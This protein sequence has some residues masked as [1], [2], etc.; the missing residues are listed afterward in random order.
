[1][2]VIVERNCQNDPIMLRGNVSLLST[3]ILILRD[4]R[5][6]TIRLHVV[7]C[8]TKQLFEEGR[9]GGGGGRAAVA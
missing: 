2:A 9:G 5:Q 3:T 1:M 4:S 8:E 6:A 7:A